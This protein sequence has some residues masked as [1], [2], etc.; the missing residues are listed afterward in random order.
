MSTL[1]TL[2]ETFGE[3]IAPFA[4]DV[5]R[6]LT[7]AFWRMSKVCACCSAFSIIA[8]SAVVAVPPCL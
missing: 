8:P 4:L 6:Q 7:A 5:V 1:E 3:Q 2:V